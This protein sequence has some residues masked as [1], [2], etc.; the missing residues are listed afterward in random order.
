ML[1]P[2]AYG[3]LPIAYCLLPIGC[4][5]TA[6]GCTNL[7]SV[8]TMHAT[9]ACEGGS[10]MDESCATMVLLHSAAFVQ[11]SFHELK[12]S[13]PLRRGVIASHDPP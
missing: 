13:E 9:L 6:K 4:A 12:A 2:M 5:G 10:V 8:A 7:F 11:T 3:L 1:W